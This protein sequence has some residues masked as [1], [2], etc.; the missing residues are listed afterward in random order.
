MLFR[1]QMHNRE[2][3]LRSG[4]H[5]HLVGI[6][7]SGLSSIARV[8]LGKGYVVTGSDQQL[9]DLTT[10]L[11][12]TGATIFEGHDSHQCQGAEVLLISSAITEDNVEVMAAR[13]ASIPI[14]KRADFLGALMVD[15]YGIAVAGS[16]GKTTTT[17]M[18]S[19]IMIEADLDPSVIVGGVLPVLGSNGRAGQ[20]EYLVIEADEYDHMFLGLKPEV[21][22]IT[23]VEYDHPDMYPTV[24][25]YQEAFAQFV[26]GIPTK[27]RIVV[28]QDDVAAKE[29]VSEYLPPDVS[30][31][32]YGLAMANWQAMDLRVNQL[33]GTDFLVQHDGQ[34]V[35][36]I[37]LR[38]PGEH[39][40]RNA[41]AAIAVAAGLGIDYGIIR[42]ALA[43]F[44]GVGRRFQVVGEVGDVTV[45]DDYAHHP[46]EIR[47]T[48]AAAKQ[49]YPGRRIWA[50]WQP[51]TFSRTK[52]LLPEFSTSFFD[53][54]RVVVLAIYQSRET[55]SLGM[56]KTAVMQ[57]MDHPDAH[58]LGD[59]EAAAG[60]V[61]DRVR[62]GDVILTL[63]AGDGNL[64][65]S[66]VLQGL[67]ER[68]TGGLPAEEEVNNSSP[69]SGN[70]RMID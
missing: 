29:L 33:G 42:R 50:V 2:F 53:A 8:L 27:G 67:D 30:L 14:L 66:I 64:V 46:T 60:Y 3:E 65:G 11:T 20:S 70:S 43:A 68:L 61:L 55:D 51:H 1:T 38:V 5:I 58:Y 28:C 54:D 35:G 23:N 16:H 15:A 37:R 22:V 31:E 39:N 19:Q 62:P 48:L 18:I 44:G 49:R 12:A 69:I 25:A 45:I 40:V 52:R 32:T 57:A 10:E 7:G 34:S 47:A 17:G 59:V 9:N 41:L 63:T 24:T 6:G 21:A 26:K 13:E 56:D 4:M 36:L